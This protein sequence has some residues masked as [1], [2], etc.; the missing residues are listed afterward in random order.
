MSGEIDTKFNFYTDTPAGKDPDAHSPTLRRYHKTLWSKALPSGRKL[1]LVD[2]HPNSYLYH[3][4]ELGEFFLTSDA[5]TH[6]YR[7]TSQIFYV[8]AHTSADEDTMHFDIVVE[9]R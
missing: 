3:K 6:S 8:I 5:I 9:P 1:E 2:T 7:N 4:S